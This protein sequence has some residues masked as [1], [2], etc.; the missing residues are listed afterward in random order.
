[1]VTR[2]DIITAARASLKRAAWLAGSTWLILLVNSN[3]M[4]NLTGH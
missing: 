1:M 4:Y 3:G 2:N